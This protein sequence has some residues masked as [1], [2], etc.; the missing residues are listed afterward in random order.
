MVRAVQRRSLVEQAAEELG[1][2][3]GEGEWAVGTRLPG[4]VELAREL[5]VGRSTVRE[6]VRALTVL[7]LLEARQGAGTFVASTTPVTDLD[8]RLRRAVIADVYEVRVALEIEAGRLAAARR[9]AADL[10]VLA[11][12]LAERDAAVDAAAFVDADLAFHRAVV[13]CAHNPVLTDV[14]DRFAGA[15]REALLDLDDDTTLRTPAD[16]AQATEAHRDLAGAI[17][18]GDVDA[19]AEATRRN[20]VVTLD[21][22]RAAVPAEGSR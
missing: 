12:R 7:G 19:A 14:F 8:S 3:V 9:T 20:V 13:A 21:Q 22:L 4:E 6:A 5:G 15:L 2:L 16:R 18:A 11:G 17:A 10:D 1:R